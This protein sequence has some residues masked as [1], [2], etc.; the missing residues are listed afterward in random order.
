[1]GKTIEDDILNDIPEQDDKNGKL[2]R[3]LTT[4]NSNLSS[5]STPLS[6]TTG[7]SSPLSGA[8]PST[9]PLSPRGTKKRPILPRNAVLGFTV[10]FTIWVRTLL[11]STHLILPYIPDD[12]GAD[13][14]HIKQPMDNIELSIVESAKKAIPCVFNYTV[15]C[16]YDHIGRFLE[17]NPTLQSIVHRPLPS[18]PSY[19]RIPH[20]MANNR[21]FIVEGT[22]S[23]SKH[24]T[25]DDETNATLNE[26]NPTI[27]PLYKNGPNGKIVSDLDEKLLSELTGRYHPGIS[28]AEADRAQYLMVTR[29]TNHYPECIPRG[30]KKGSDEGYTWVN[31]PGL[32]LLDANLQ[33]I[34]GAD[35]LIDIEK[36]YFA[37]RNTR[38]FQ[39]FTIFAARTT[40]GNKKKDHLFLMT[41]GMYALPL[42][43]RRVPP[44]MDNDDSKWET[45]INRT[46]LP[47]DFLIGTGLQVRLPHAYGDRLHDLIRDKEHSI[48]KFKTKLQIEDGKNMRIFEST[49]GTTYIE[50]WPYNNHSVKSVNLYSNSFRRFKDF[51]WKT[52]KMVTTPNLR[53]QPSFAKKPKLSLKSPTNR[54]TGCCADLTLPDGRQVKLGIAHS[55]TTDRHYLHRFYAFLP[56]KPFPIVALSGR[57]CLGSMTSEDVDV[58]N[59]WMSSQ[60]GA[61]GRNKEKLGKKL[62]DCPEITFASGMANMIGHEGNYIIISYGIGDCYA[63]SIFVHKRKIEMLMFPEFLNTTQGATTA[64]DNIL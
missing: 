27:L 4:Q 55:V 43:I 59:H 31:Y 51:E 56:E 64:A 58:K 16:R 37:K 42:A 25:S 14:D 50:V 60:K 32:A 28:D 61:F 48:S 2:K 47:S 13:F 52:G 15:V 34:E 6:M 39:D 3:Q 62:Y 7:P 40:P 53:G 18:V 24:A 8:S 35:I 11:T 10:V 17:E 54:G 12:Y 38:L 20:E 36:Y 21:T 5:P 22:S 45:K 63:R 44:G 26:Y 23:F 19:R 1:M 29:S 33:I 57:F 41:N 30:F 9:K 46:N 49:N